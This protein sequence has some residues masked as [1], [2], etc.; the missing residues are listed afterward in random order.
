MISYDIPD[1]KRRKKVYDLLSG[2]GKW[3]Q[4]SVFECVLTPRQF[5]E[6]QQR[7]KKRVKLQ[8]DSIRFYPLSQHTLGQIEAWGVSE[9]ITQL[10]GSTIV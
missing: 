1:D 7:L 5:R 9:P 2:Y 4:L 3:V 6:L 8:E 10:P